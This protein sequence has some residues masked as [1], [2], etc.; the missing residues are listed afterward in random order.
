MWSWFALLL[1]PFAGITRDSNPGLAPNTSVGPARSRSLGHPH[2]LDIGIYHASLPRRRRALYIQ[3]AV[4]NRPFPPRTRW[5]SGVIF[6]PLGEQT[7]D[8]SST[9]SHRYCV[10]TLPT[11]VMI[12]LSHRIQK[13]GTA[14]EKAAPA[15]TRN[16]RA[17][18][19]FLVSGGAPRYT[20]QGNRD[21]LPARSGLCRRLIGTGVRTRRRETAFDPLLALIDLH[22]ARTHISDLDTKTK[23]QRNLLKHNCY[24]FECKFNR[25]CNA[26]RRLEVPRTR[27]I[28]ARPISRARSANKGRTSFAKPKSIA[29]LC[30]LTTSSLERSARA[31]RRLCV[32]TSPASESPGRL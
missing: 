30:G 21:N 6:R 10:A 26:P 31:R 8:P 20:G 2:R 14:P 28:P 13:R 23:V 25:I 17:I 29:D 4:P 24:S 16:V 12:A 15:I 22:C 27:H 1:K 5:A 7:P 32:E 18:W 19:A 3:I 11:R 9:I